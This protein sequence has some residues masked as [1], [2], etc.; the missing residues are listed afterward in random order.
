M[1][2]VI[3]PAL[4]EEHNIQACIENIKSEEFRC[5]IIVADGGSTDG[6]VELAEK[7]DGVKVIRTGKG[8]GVQM[9]KGASYAAGEILL[10]LHADTKLEGGWGSEIMSLLNNAKSL[11]GGAFTFKIDNP[12][13]QFRLIEQWVKFRSSIFRL[14]YGDQGIFVR[15]NAFKKL[16]GYKNIPLMEDVDFVE[17]MKK[18]G[19]ITILGKKAFTS[20]RKWLKNGWIRVSVMNQAIMI[21]YRLGADPHKLAKLYYDER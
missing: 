8:R 3:I 21:M 9:N 20:G 14:P 18:A 13:I 12:E 5:E 7:Y 4:N 2:S 17:R 1:I 6:T 10:F 15:S 16:G 11:I 19:R